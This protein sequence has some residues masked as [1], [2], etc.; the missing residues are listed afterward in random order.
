V[1]IVQT[2]GQL[3]LEKHPNQSSGVLS[4]ASW[5]DGFA[6]L[7][8]DQTFTRGQLVPYISFSQLLS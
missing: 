5:A 3:I 7:E 1:R 2:D 4:S 6:V 8:L